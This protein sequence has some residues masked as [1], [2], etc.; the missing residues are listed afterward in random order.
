MQ[1]TLARM[2]L[3]RAVL[4]VSPMSGLIH[5]RTM[6]A[7]NAGCVAIAEDNLGSK[8]ILQHK[9][10]ALLFRYDDDSLDECLDIMCNQPER[11]CKIAEAGCRLRDDPRIRFGQFHNIIRLAQRRP[12]SGAI[13]P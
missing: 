8:G 4:S 3:C 10:N 7:L 1:F 11:C 12:E 6:N 5:D 2:S 13:H 9:E